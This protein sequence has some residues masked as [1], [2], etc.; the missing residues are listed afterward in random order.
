[1]KKK[2][3]I[4]IDIH[5]R[6]NDV[7]RILFEEMP[8]G[9]VYIKEGGEGYN[10]TGDYIVVDKNETVWGIERKSYLDCYQSI[11]SKRAYGQ[12]C[13]LLDQYPDHAIL[14]LEAPTYFPKALRG[15]Q[16]EIMASVQSFFCERSFEMPC[17]FVYGARGSAH[18]IM[19][20]ANCAHTRKLRGRGIEVIHVD[21]NGKA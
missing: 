10:P 7:S 15:R 11:I 20:H 4:I 21:N 5:E 9:T 2:P 1:M 8:E 13:Q 12:L 18:Q 3:K 6:E 17:W 16:A 19:K 14:M